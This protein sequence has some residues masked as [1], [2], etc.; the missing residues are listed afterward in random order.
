MRIE[1]YKEIPSP[2]PDFDSIME[3]NIFI[4][5]DETIKEIG[6]RYKELLEMRGDGTIGG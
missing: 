5:D 1:I 3:G 6:D 2:L 4:I